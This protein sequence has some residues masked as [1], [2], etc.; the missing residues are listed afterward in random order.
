M[1]AIGC[2]SLVI[3]PL[4]ELAVDGYIGG[5][6]AAIWSAGGGLMFA[7]LICGVAAMALVKTGRR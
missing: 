5:L 2:L 3:L 7:V 1:I 6:D 4:I